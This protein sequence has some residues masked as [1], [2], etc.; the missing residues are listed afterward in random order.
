MLR[1]LR[2]RKEWLFF[3][4]LP[5]AD[6]R[7]ALT[8]WVVV[9]LHGLLPAMFAV[10]MGRVV[11]AV[12]HGNAITTPLAFLGIA[13]VLLQVLTPVQTAVSH[14]LGDRTAAYL[15]DRL[16]EMAV[17][18]PGLAHLEKDEGHAEDAERA[19]QGLAALHRVD[20]AAHRHGKQRRQQSVQPHHGPPRQGQAAIR[21]RQRREEE[22][23][24]PLT[25]PPQHRLGPSLTGLTPQLTCVEDPSARRS[26]DSARKGWGV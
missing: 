5:K 14:N 6:R 1:R 4:A 26:H 18:P 2:E 3:A 15:Y 24:L 25:H 22:P 17:R 7:L 23:L 12:Q 20:E 9:W 8:W 16:T 13:F 19:R 10:A 11:E 21:L